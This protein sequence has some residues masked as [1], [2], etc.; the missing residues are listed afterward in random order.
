[1]NESELEIIPL[2]V[3]KKYGIKA[4]VLYGIGCGIGGSIFIL[5]GTGIGIAGPGVLLSLLLGGILILLIALNYSELSASLPISG[6]AYNF[7]KEGIGGFSAYIIGFFL[8]IAS[9]ATF[10]FSAQALAL[11]IVIF[12][13]FLNNYLFIIIIS[14]FSG[15]F[16]SIVFFRTQRFA[17]RTFIILTI[18]LI[19]IF[20]VFI[21]SGLLIS[22]YTNVSGYNPNFIYSKASFFGVIQMFALLF[23]FFTSITSNLAYFNVDLKNPSKNILKVN[24]LAILITLLIYLSISYVVLINIGNKIDRIGDSPILLG[25]ILSDI[26]GPVGFYL[27]G[28]AAIISILIAMNAAL[29]SAVSVF[30]A[31][32]R[33]HY[34]PKIFNKVSK[35]S[36]VPTYSLIIT[37]IIAIFFTFFAIIYANIGLTAEITIFIYFFGLAF[38]N[39]AAVNLRYKRKELDRPFKAPFFPFL[40]IIVAITC[41]ILAFILE[42]SAIILGL[43]IFAIA[44][45]YYLLTIADRYSLVITL[46]GIKLICLI[47]VGLFIWMIN[48]VSVISVTISGFNIFFHYVL[49]RILIFICIFTI[50]TIVLDIVPLRE[51]IYFFTKKLDKERVA[52]DLGFGQIIEL[53]KMR[54]KILQRVNLAIAIGQIISS[55]FVFFM[56]YLFGIEIVSIEKITIG[57]INIS[58]IMAEYFWLAG[59]ILLGCSLLVSGVLMIYVNREVL[60]LG[61]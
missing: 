50:G 24:I 30:Q 27:M 35:K 36:N 53:D 47:F 7:S 45:I 41:L 28:I 19:A 11:I 51:F 34:F 14:V 22:P 38:V 43:I 32:S 15:L 1:M 10:S 2:E 61:V 46:A 18:I 8:W 9:I 16:I 58:H 33:D 52:I 13:P 4:G 31:L 21:F 39:L 44:V 23:I 5:L 42:P 48:N 20:C 54:L 29:G 26:L 56:I 55:L 60:S 25:E 57:N 17:V 12:F 49:L 59:L 37:T 40:P 3:E 6:G